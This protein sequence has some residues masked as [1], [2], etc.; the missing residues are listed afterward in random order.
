MCVF[1]S[2]QAKQTLLSH[3]DI[4]KLHFGLLKR[5]QVRTGALKGL[6]YSDKLRSLTDFGTKLSLVRM[7][8]HF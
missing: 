8:L 7:V 1:K 6:S 3:I 4:D 2:S 5:I